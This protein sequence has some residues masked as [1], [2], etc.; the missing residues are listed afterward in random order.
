MLQLRKS[1]LLGLVLISLAACARDSSFPNIRIFDADRSVNAGEQGSATTIPGRATGAR[2]PASGFHSVARGET[3]FAIS[4]QYGVPLRSLIVENRLSPP[5][6]LR[7]GQQLRIP[8]S[9]SHTVRPGD[10]VYGISRTY[11]VSMTELVRLNQIEEPF[12]IH[13]DQVLVIPARPSSGGSQIAATRRE[14]PPPA[15]DRTVQAPPPPRGTDQAQNPDQNPDPAEPQP[16]QTPPPEPQ[17]AIQ[18][19]PSRVALSD[20]PAEPEY[21]RGETIFP[22][23]K[24][25]PPPRLAGPIPTPPPLSGDGFLWPVQGRILSDYGPKGRGLHNDGINIAAPRG[26]AI[27]AAENG[28]VAYS[29]DGLQGFGRII[30]IKH[31][32]NYVTAYAHAEEILVQRGQEIQRGQAIARVG[33]SGTVDRPQVHFQIRRGRDA[34]DPTRLL[35]GTS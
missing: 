25:Q 2:P 15:Q 31:R 28:V 30:L 3:L 16:T 7:V 8:I 19:E 33:S 1:L 10:T 26:T 12:T 17:P 35:S 24:P 5:F 29:G 4:R 14:T 27:R 22:N 18:E 20:V 34:I 6:N 11:G 23:A 9:R 21:G 32:D 13:V